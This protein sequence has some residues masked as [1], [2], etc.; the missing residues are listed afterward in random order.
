MTFAGIVQRAAVG[1]SLVSAL[2]MQGRSIGGI[3]PDVTIEEHHTDDLT[4]TDH[5][6]EQGA[7]ITDHAFKNPSE[8]TMHV[9][10]TNANLLLS[11]IVSGSI[12]SGTIGSVDDLYN[13]LLALQESRQVFDLVTGKRTYNNML[14]K[15]IAVT[16]NKDTE[17]CL[18]VAITMRQVIIVQTVATIL[19]PI[20]AQS[21]P[22][23]T[24][25]VQNAG[26]KIVKP[27]TSSAL[28]TINGAVGG[29]IR[30]PGMGS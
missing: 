8:V 11:S 10:W 24:G 4:I 15:R 3:I 6:V 2:F 26:S 7:A 22:S 13:K 1:I 28:G 18:I 14:I 27:V 30:L 16:T 21:Q 23:L 19:A 9:G 12:F 5:P 20:S 25:A 17:N 29:V